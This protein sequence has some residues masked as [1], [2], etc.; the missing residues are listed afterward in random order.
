MR[1]V[2][3]YRPGGQQVQTGRFYGLSGLEPRLGY[4]D[5]GVGCEIDP[6]GHLE[7]GR[8]HV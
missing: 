5:R 4:Y 6:Q 2:R 3:L 1:Y 7:I 8:A